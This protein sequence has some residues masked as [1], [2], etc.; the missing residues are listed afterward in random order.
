MYFLQISRH[1]AESCPAFNEHTKKSTVALLQKMDSLL[2]KH[3]VK[4]AGMWNDHPAHMVYN[5]YDSPSLEA[6]MAL[7]MEPEMMAWLAYNTADLEVVLGPQEIK[8]MFNLG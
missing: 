4:I 3:G 1:T 7:T 2:A 5:I 6:M 8:A